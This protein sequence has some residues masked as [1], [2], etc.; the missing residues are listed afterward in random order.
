MASSTRGRC[1]LIGAAVLVIALVTALAYFALGWQRMDA[2][3][4]TDAAVPQGASPSS[5]GYAW[6]W[7]PP[8]FAC[9]WDGADGQPVTV[10]KLWW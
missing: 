6:S 7:A 3:C 9:T 2:A 1:A 5:V 10:V 4:S 8:G